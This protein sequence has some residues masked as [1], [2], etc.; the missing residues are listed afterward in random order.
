MLFWLELRSKLPLCEFSFAKYRCWHLQYRYTCNCK[1]SQRHHQ[2]LLR[3]EEPKTKFV[4]VSNTVTID[5]VSFQ[6]GAQPEILKILQLSILSTSI[7][8][9]F[10]LK[11]TQPNTHTHT[12]IVGLPS[13]QATQ[14]CKT[15]MEP[16]PDKVMPNAHTITTFEL[17]NVSKQ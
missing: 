7:H 17:S 12:Q 15:L 3:W 8:M 4:F 1:Y 2:M 13:H 9:Y 11:H 6:M 16:T 5:S 14:Q 10:A